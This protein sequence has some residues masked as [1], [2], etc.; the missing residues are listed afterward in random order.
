MHAQPQPEPRVPPGADAPPPEPP[1]LRQ[2]AAELFGAGRQQFAELLELFTLEV[3]YSG[4]MLGNSVGL[5]LVAAL[6][7][8]T[9]WGLLVAALVAALLELGL[10]WSAALL[11]VAAVNAGIVAVC[12]WLL[13]HT[14]RRVGL[15][16][17]RRAMG[18]EAD[19]VSH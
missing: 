18:L 10:G 19:D 8:F 15:R 3:R 7:G 4:L 6:A 2:A 5:L 17:T 14:L 16:H 9:V 11:A 1:S 12:L 13:R